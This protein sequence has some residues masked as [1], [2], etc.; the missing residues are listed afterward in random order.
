MIVLKHVGYKLK[1]S[2]ELRNLLEHLKQTTSQIDGVVLKISIF[3]KIK[4]NL[5]YFLSAKAKRNI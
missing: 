2:D 3:T 1:D 4:M 5:F